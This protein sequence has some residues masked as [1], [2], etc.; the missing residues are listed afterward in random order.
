L[1][2][3]WCDRVRLGGLAADAFAQ[4]NSVQVRCT[5]EDAYHELLNS[6]VVNGQLATYLPTNRYRY[7]Y[8]DVFWTIA[9]FPS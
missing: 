3:D 6:A 1:L 8:S 2:F 7:T 5:N 4:G 9:L